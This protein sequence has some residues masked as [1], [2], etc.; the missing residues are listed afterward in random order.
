VTGYARHAAAVVIGALLGA[1]TLLWGAVAVVEAWKREGRRVEQLVDLDR[2]DPADE[3]LC[4]V[5]CP[6]LYGPRGTDCLCDR[7]CKNPKC[8]SADTGVS[9]WSAEDLAYLRGD[10]EMP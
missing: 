10:K 9:D 3:L 5:C 2:H 8:P 6:P 1:G 7:K 4:D